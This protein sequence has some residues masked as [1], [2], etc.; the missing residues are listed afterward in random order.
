MANLRTAMEDPLRMPPGYGQTHKWT[1]R[2]IFWDLPYWRTNLIRHNLDVM[3]IEKN[4]FDAVFGT[5]MDIK[6]KTK[7]GLKSRQDIHVMCD[8]PR[9]A[10]DPA[11]HT[12]SIPKAVYNLTKEEQK[13]ILEWLKEL[14]FPDGYASNIGR[15]V[16]VDGRNLSKMKSHDCH[17]FM[18]R[19]L[20]IAFKEMLP[21]QLWN[22]IT[23]LSLLFRCL[24]SAMLDVSK[25]RELVAKVPVIMCN[26]EK[27]FP[28]SFFDSMEHVVVHLP[29]EALIGGPVQF[30]WMYV[31][32]RYVYLT[33][34][35]H[36]KM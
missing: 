1:K 28:P 33:Y 31:F 17:V 16:H 14:K 19:L 10:V 4:V 20:P 23:E 11:M 2:S 15:C 26:L 32:E 5:L 35:T 7:D 6:G 8:R 24:C 12:N 29:L 21:A 34:L 25:V 30:R 27:V 18:Q 9:I 13:S 3:H 22:A 36:E